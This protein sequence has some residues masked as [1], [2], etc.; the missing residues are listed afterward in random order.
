SLLLNKIK[1]KEKGGKITS[2]RDK[3]QIL[4][5]N[6]LLGHID[7]VDKYKTTFKCNK[8]PLTD[9]KRCTIPATETFQHWIDDLQLAHSREHLVK[10]FTGRSDLLPCQ[11]TSSQLLPHKL[12]QWIRPAILDL[13]RY[14]RIP[15]FDSDP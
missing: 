11:Q 4:F 2:Y 9:R 13:I 15:T 10:L 14:R 6:T 5:Y 12:V 8:R 3:E 7:F 1:G